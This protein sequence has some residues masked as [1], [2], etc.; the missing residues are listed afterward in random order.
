MSKRRNQKMKYR[1]RGFLLSAWSALVQSG[2]VRRMA[3][4]RIVRIGI[5]VVVM[6]AD[7]FKN[8]LWHPGRRLFRRSLK[9][10]RQREVLPWCITWIICGVLGF[11]ICAHVIYMKIVIGL[12]LAISF[13]LVCLRSSV[14]GLLLWVLLAPLMWCFLK[15]RL[16]PGLPLVSVDRLCLP[17]LIIAYLAT[18]QRIRKAETNWPLHL[19]IG[20]YLL[21]V[22]LGSVR[23]VK[24][25]SA[26]TSSVIDMLLPPI[27][28]M[29]ARAW[30]SNKSAL[31]WM[32]ITYIIMGL[33]FAGMGIP[34]H[35]LGHGLVSRS[36]W[37][38]KELGTVRIQGPASSPTD[39]GCI[40]ILSF[41]LLLAKFTQDKHGFRRALYLVGMGILAT[42]MVLT[43]RRAVYVSV[44]IA[45]L[46]MSIPRSRLRRPAVVLLSLLV[47]AVFIGWRPLVNSRV[48][49][50][51]IGD[52]VPIYSRII[53][54]A[55]AWSMVK[56]HPI[57]GV[58][59]G[60]FKE[61]KYAYLTSYKGLN[62]VYGQ[63]VE[64]PHNAYLKLL[65]EG[66]IVALLPFLGMIF[67]IVFTSVKLFRRT[68]S[69]GLMGREG[70]VVFWA[71]TAVFLAQSF[72]GDAFYM[73]PS[74]CVA[75]FVFFGGIVGVH[76]RDEESTPVTETAPAGR[77]QYQSARRGRTFPGNAGYVNRKVE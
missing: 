4:V 65:A 62:T 54:Q 70:I 6:L 5:P 3:G 44:P 2:P 1:F 16:L 27:T 73:L 60:N 22:L 21:I 28:Y 67:M 31:R 41:V 68:R 47:L 63:G 25:V 30:I 23:A 56:Q 19:T 55:T 72:Q 74:T 50:A 37:V 18:A 7:L 40:C 77:A 35:F 49:K 46:V 43:L 51:R 42:A 39:L 38:E 57:F 36:G 33:Y 26:F 69:E 17:I 14:S 34:E 61:V 9:F 32:F 10:L 71:M 52:M 24:P 76:M 48:F 59:M 45:L 66:G 75:W 58:G 29:M 8:Y 13:T 53:I 64:T 20:A 15:L 12:V 11:A